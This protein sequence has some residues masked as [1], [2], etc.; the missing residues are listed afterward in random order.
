MKRSIAMALLVVIPGASIQSFAADQPVPAAEAAAQ[1]WLG[2]LDNANY[3]QSWSTAAQHFRDSI[4]QSEWESRIAA[5]RG[6]LG[7]VKSRSVTSATFRRTL[8]GAPDGE[9][10]VI[11][12]STSFEHKAEAIETVTPVREPDG[13]WRV[14]GYYIR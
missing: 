3:A 12:F 8:P 10:V 7:A 11:Q 4:A 2:L 6:P 14:G 9:Y 1:A 13:Q 5:R